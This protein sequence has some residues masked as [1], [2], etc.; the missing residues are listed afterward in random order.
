MCS[1]YFLLFFF[2]AVK[3]PV[4]LRSC[5]FTR[6]VLEADP[7]LI[8]PLPPPPPPPAL[9]VAPNVTVDLLEPPFSLFGL[10]DGGKPSAQELGD[11]DEEEEEERDEEED[12]RCRG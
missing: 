2:L 12:D 3:Q 10:L 4:L 7:L 6:G 8:C 9:W 11:E 1:V 5:S